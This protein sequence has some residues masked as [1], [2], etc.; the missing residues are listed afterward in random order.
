M[1]L[2]EFCTERLAEDEQKA[3]AASDGPWR[4]NE[5]KYHHLPGTSLISEA[6]FAGPA[7][8]D[9]LCVATTGDY[10]DPQS[11]RD[12]DHI[13]RHDP[14]RALRQVE[15]GRRTLARHK[16]N[17]Q[18]SDMVTWADACMGCG[19]TGPC[20]DPNTEHMDE[21][22]ELRNLASIWA[23]HDDYLPRWAV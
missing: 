8:P 13:A 16:P 9:A 21:C 2:M 17:P 12:A 23:D 19:V 7:G 5:R 11:M 15:A 22:P 4:Y 3:R 14:T 10:D 6:V 18:W 1:T 20:G